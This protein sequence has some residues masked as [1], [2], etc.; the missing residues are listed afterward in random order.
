MPLA[1][2]S[3]LQCVCGSRNTVM[4][5]ISVQE[6]PQGRYFQYIHRNF[7]WVAHH[8]S[9]NLLCAHAQLSSY[10]LF[11]LG[12]KFSQ[13]HVCHAHLCGEWYGCAILN[14]H[15]GQLGLMGGIDS[16]RTK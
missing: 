2:M 13:H 3:S 10:K 8:H 14:Q 5:A 9:Y 11:T 1:L 12:Y 16:M 15:R 6:G 7:K 4:L